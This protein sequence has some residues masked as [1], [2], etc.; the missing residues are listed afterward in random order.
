MRFFTAR[1]TTP[2]A[3]ERVRSILAAAHSM[4]VVCDGMHTELRRL[5][6]TGTMGHFHLHA[7]SEDTGAQNAMRVPVRLEFTDIA[8]TPVRDRLRARV[9]LTGLLA[10]PYD[11]EAT[12]SVCMAFGQAVLEDAQ[13]RAYVT[14]HALGA[15]Q[16]DP[17]ATSEAS[18]LTHLVDDHSELIPLLLRLVRP[19]P[20]S[21]LQRALPVAMDRHG[22]TLRLEYRHTHRD[23]RLPFKTAVTDIDQAGP[24]IQAL[25]STARRL[26]RAGHLLP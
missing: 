14:M 21:G 6:G 19:Q 13:G 12:E 5:D 3:A 23:V 1:A 8:P 4:T 22:V 9:T 17:I 16:P 10:A 2:T 25:L 24:Q 20:D 7:P 26:S 15:A 18:M 11:E